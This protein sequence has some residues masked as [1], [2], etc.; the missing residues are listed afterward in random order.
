MGNALWVSWHLSTAWKGNVDRYSGSFIPESESNLP[1]GAPIVRTDYYTNSGFD[2]GHLCP[3]D[4]QDGNADENRSTFVLTNILPQ[5]P[6]LNRQAWYR[7]EEYTRSLI[8][9]GNECY[10]IAGADR[11]GGIGDKGEVKELGTGKA[12]PL[13]VPAWFWK[14]IVVLPVGS[15]D[16]QRINAQTRVIA[17]RIPNRNEAGAESWTAYRTSVDAIEAITGLNLLSRL[18]SS[19]QAEIESKRDEVPVPVNLR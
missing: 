1:A 16:L 5:A 18:T 7:L 13:N 2:R 9:Q 3:S 12:A 17:I 15:N 14:V 11:S 4:D 6:A 10:I 8:S 19:L